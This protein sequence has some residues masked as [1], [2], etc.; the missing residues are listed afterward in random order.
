LHLESTPAYNVHVF[1][2]K[3]EREVWWPQAAWNLEITI[4]LIAAV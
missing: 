4:I 3:K 2:H 1:T